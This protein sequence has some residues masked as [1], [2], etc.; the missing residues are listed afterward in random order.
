VS[1]FLY[2]FDPNQLKTT[3]MDLITTHNKAF[4]LMKKHG[5]VAMG[6]TF[7]FDNAKR[8]FGVCRYRSRVIGLSRELTLLNS[9]AEVVDTIL[10]EIAHALTPRHHH[11]AV[12]RAKA[13]E[14]GCN[15]E[16]CYSSDD[17]KTP[18]GNYEAICPCCKHTHAKFKAPSKTKRASCGNCGNGK[19]DIAKLLIW[20]K[21]K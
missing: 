5:L 11:D 17:V 4:E 9:E 19:F 16:R 2:I 14:I 3:T 20:E 18:K 7:K 21:V 15:G 13:I 12:W 8:R 6:W 1:L 10:H